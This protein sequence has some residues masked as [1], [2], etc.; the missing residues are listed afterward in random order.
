M[1]SE[2]GN[3]DEEILVEEE[4]DVTVAALV[5]VSFKVLVSIPFDKVDDDKLRNDNFVE[6]RLVDKKRAFVNLILNFKTT[7]SITIPKDEF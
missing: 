3:V 1:F 6:R 2:S 4:T 7:I 5:G